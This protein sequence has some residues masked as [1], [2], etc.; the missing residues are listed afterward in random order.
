MITAAVVAAGRRTDLADQLAANVRHTYIAMLLGA[1]MGWPFGMY[2]SP[3]SDNEKKSFV[4]AGQAAWRLCR[5]ICPR[6]WTARSK[7]CGANLQLGWNDAFSQHAQPP[8][9]ERP[10]QGTTL[11]TIDH[12]SVSALVPA[13]QVL[14]PGPGRDDGRASPIDRSHETPSLGSTN[15]GAASRCPPA[16]LGEWMKRTCAFAA[17]EHISTVR[18][19]L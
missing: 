17:D 14:V 13:P 11:R 9:Q 12:R 8:E 15:A 18:L 1:V 4:S 19:I 6:N 3:Y 5:A 7:G 16:R 2:F 10:V